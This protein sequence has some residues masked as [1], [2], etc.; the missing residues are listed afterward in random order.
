[1]KKTI[2]NKPVKDA[3]SRKKF[4]LGGYSV[5]LIC[6]VLA[7]LVAVNLIAGEL[8]TKY[9]HIDVS[10][11]QL[12]SLSEEN[13]E[14][15]SQLDED[16]TIY[17]ITTAGTENNKMYE[18]LSKYAAE[19]SHID[20]IVKDPSLY[21]NFVSQYTTATLNDG[22]VIVERGDKNKVIDFSSIF[23]LDYNTYYSTAKR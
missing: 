9:T 20:L 4:R 2:H 15:L 18:I 10:E 17:L 13:E 14:Y 11:L 1:M 21:P 12:F 19:S 3:T 5:A 22:S 23:A 16:V 6:I 8:P 7:L